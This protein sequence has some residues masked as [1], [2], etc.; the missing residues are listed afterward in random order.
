MKTDVLIPEPLFQKA[1]ALAEKLRMSRNELYAKAVSAFVA[2]H[3][4]AQITEQLN[5]VYSKQPSTPDPA[6]ARMQAASLP[7]EEW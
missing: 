5:Q 2:Q 3:D 1:E 6:L 4:E 7:V